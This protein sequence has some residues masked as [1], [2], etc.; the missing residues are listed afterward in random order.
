MPDMA[1]I[2]AALSGV[3]TAAEIAKILKDSASSLEQAEIKLKFAELIG[4]LADV[5]IELADIQAVVQEKDQF[6]AELEKKLQDSS[7]TV[8]FLGARYMKNDAGKPSG[9]P[10]CPTCYAKSK[11]N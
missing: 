1:S 8:G 4:A 9:V 10:F 7:E 3:K 11:R 6:I 5:K 2:A